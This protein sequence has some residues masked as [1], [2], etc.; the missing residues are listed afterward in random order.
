MIF[1]KIKK[2]K[3]K[4]SSFKGHCF[5]CLATTANINNP[6]ILFGSFRQADD[7]LCA[8]LIFRETKQIPVII[9]SLDKYIAKF[10]I[11]CEVKAGIDLC[12]ETNNLISPER[13][14]YFKPNDFTVEAAD[15]WIAHRIK[16]LKDTKICIVGAGN[17]GSKLALRLA[18]RGSIVRLVGLRFDLLQIKVN[19]LNLISRG[20][21][22]IFA[23]PSI[24]EGCSDANAIIG[25][26]PGIAAIND[27]AVGVSQAELLLDI[28]NGCFDKSAILRARQRKK[29]LEVLSPTAGW[30]GFF[31]RYLVTKKLHSSMGCRQLKS[32]IRIVSRG[33]LGEAGDILVDDILKPKSIIGICNGMGDLIYN[34]EAMQKIKSA[35]KS[36]GIN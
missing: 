8:N 21:G 16:K 28:G 29:S 34:R 32:G 10:F 22:S 26:T 19:G 35:E 18:E 23:C 31:R 14:Y 17:I 36:L 27:E 25:C 1:D 30:E 7:F 2:I 24:T 20:S 4:F 11:D 5:L 12:A 33:L 6:P 9:K 13:R 3:D 15:E